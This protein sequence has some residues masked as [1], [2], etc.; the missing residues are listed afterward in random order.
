MML[1]CL[2]CG[3]EWEPRKPN[4]KRCPAC[5]NPTWNTPYRRK[6]PR[7]ETNIDKPEESAIIGSVSVSS[8]TIDPDGAMMQVAPVDRVAE[9]KRKAMD[10]YMKVAQ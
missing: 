5:Q 1:T 6:K 4:P 10:L 9:A 3:N 7:P 2:R 8:G